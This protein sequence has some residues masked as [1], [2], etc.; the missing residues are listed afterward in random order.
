MLSELIDA[1]RALEEG[2]TVSDTVDPANV[3]RCVCVSQYMA[4]SFYGD[5]ANILDVP[6]VQIDVY[7]VSILDTLPDQICA[8]LA[9]WHL[10]YTLEDR[11][12]DADTNRIRTILQTEVI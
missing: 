9:D 2:L 7:T 3:A 4:A 1:I 10:P 6:K 11:G 5:D 8:L 12:Y